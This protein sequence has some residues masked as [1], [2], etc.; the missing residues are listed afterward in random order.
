MQRLT[1]GTTDPAQL[2]RELTPRAIV[3]ELDRH[4]VG[5]DDAKRAVA[6]AIRNRWRRKQ[7][8]EDM[9]SEVSPKNILM[10]GPTGVGKT[11]IARRL[12]KLTNA[13]FIKVE[14][15]KYTEVGYVGRDVESIVRD[16]VEVGLGLIKETKRKEVR[17]KAN[18][19]GIELHAGTWSICPTSKAFKNKWGTAEEHL[20]L[21]IKVAKAL[22]SPIIRCVLGMGEDR[23]TEGG[24]EAR[25]ADTVRVCQVCRNRAMD[26]GVRIAIENHGGDMQAKELVALIAT[27][28]SQVLVLNRQGKLLRQFVPEVV[29]LH[30][31]VADING[32]KKAEIVVAGFMGN[33]RVGRTWKRS[34]RR[35]DSDRASGDGRRTF[36]H[37]GH[38]RR[39]ADGQRT[40]C[41]SD[42]QQWER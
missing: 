41:R 38:E 12:A 13:L 36:D 32:D 23:K 14:A 19:L 25:M 9:R 15:T 18:D 40:R 4:I 1:G 20:A 3:A 22:G 16:L 5:Q 27:S 24:I 17:A 11:E 35:T 33:R 39:P 21:G 30:L 34:D 28:A 2:L 37:R 29:A 10:I 8:G 6:I 42:Q 7:L 31:Q 26:A